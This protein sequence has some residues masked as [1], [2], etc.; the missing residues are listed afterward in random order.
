MWWDHVI[1]KNKTLRFNVH[2]T[3]E[4]GGKENHGIQNIGTKNSPANITVGDK[5]QVLKICENYVI[6]VYK[7][8]KWPENL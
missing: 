2:N 6:E 4:P 8:A 3:K 7:Q 1:K 5:R